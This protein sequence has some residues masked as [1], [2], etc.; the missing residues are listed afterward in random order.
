MNVEQRCCTPQQVQTVLLELKLSK[1]LVGSFF[2]SV[3]DSIP[4]SYKRVLD[5]CKVSLKVA[6]PKLL[7]MHRT[8]KGALGSE[9]SCLHAVPE[10]HPQPRE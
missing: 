7:A 6:D 9:Q 5:G 1:E 8:P 3:S 10:S 4:T 2:I